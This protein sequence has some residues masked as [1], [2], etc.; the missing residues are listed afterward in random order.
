M[1]NFIRLA[2]CGLILLV[3][4]QATSPSPHES[5]TLINDKLGHAL[6]FFLLGYLGWTG[7]HRT[8]FIGLMF[9]FLV[10]YGLLIEVVQYY[11]PGREFSLLDWAADIAGLI[12]AWTV[13]LL[14]KCQC[15]TKLV[16][17]EGR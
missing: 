14:K 17:D 9:A 6:V 7:W 1:N 11:V 3:F 4:W 10:F 15:M 8:R 16:I 12:A 13:V 5:T 2:W